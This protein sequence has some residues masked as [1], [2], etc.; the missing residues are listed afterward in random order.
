MPRPLP[1]ASSGDKAKRVMLYRFGAE[2]GD[3]LITAGLLSRRNAHDCY[4]PAQQDRTQRSRWRLWRRFVFGRAVMH[5]SPQE[6]ALTPCRD[7]RTSRI[8]QSNMPLATPLNFRRRLLVDGTWD[9]MPSTCHPCAC[10]AEIQPS[11]PF[12]NASACFRAASLW[13]PSIRASSVTRD[14]LSSNLISEIVRPSFTCL[15]T[16]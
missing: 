16:T 7:I 11:Y 13:P 4:S 14:F 3:S 5:Q 15:V 12:S 8:R 10:R 9:K 1:V 2:A 6:S